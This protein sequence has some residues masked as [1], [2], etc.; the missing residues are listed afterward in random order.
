M[1]VL[2]EL[3][4]LLEVQEQTL[5]FRMEILLLSQEYLL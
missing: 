1:L 5:P 3:L 2:V 4:D